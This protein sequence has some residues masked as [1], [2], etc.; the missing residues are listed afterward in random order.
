MGFERGLCVITKGILVLSL[1]VACGHAET[2]DYNFVGMGKAVDGVPAEPVAFH[3]TLPSFADPPMDSGFIF[4]TCAQTDASTNC[5]TALMPNNAISFSNQ[6]ALGAFSAQLTFA[7]AD[8]VEYVFVFPTGAFG[9]P[10]VYTTGSTFDPGTLTVTETPEPSTVLL[11]LS[12]VCLSG[13]F[14]WRT[15]RRIRQ[16]TS[17][18]TSSVN[19]TSRLY[20]DS[21]PA[22][23]RLAS[24]KA[25]ISNRVEWTCPLPPNSVPGSNG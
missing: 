3:L 15:K 23:P 17:Q 1:A 2:I 24:L 6:S 10:G 9:T 13:F 14:K 16:R 4:F 19:P 22:L 5:D 11:A 7:A 20:N 18:T 12:G 8:L 25:L 21:L